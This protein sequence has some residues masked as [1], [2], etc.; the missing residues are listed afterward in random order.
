MSKKNS[1]TSMALGI[2][3]VVLG[4]NGLES[5][6]IMAVAGLV[7]AILSMNFKKKADAEEKSQDLILK[8]KTAEHSLEALKNMA[9]RYEGFGNS[10]KTVME[11]KA[12]ESG[13]IGVVSDLISVDKK[14]EVAIE[15]A[16]G[17]NIQNIVTEDEATA[18]FIPDS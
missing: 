12:N 5:Y 14:Y 11:E 15:T 8:I 1:I 17:G 16:L 18:S 3:S 6:G 10:V 13:L 4:L 7:C 2:A 9:E